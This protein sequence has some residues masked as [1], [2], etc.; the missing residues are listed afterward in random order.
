[1]HLGQNHLCRPA[2]TPHCHHIIFISSFHVFFFFYV[3]IDRCG[4]IVAIL[5]VTV[6][7][8][9]TKYW[10]GCWR[11]AVPQ[12]S[13]TLIV[14]LM[15]MNC[16]LPFTALFVWV[17]KWLLFIEFRYIFRRFFLFSI[18]MCLPS[19]AWALLYAIVVFAFIAFLPVLPYCVSNGFLCRFFRCA[20]STL[21]HCLSMH[22]S[23]QCA[24]FT[25]VC[26]YVYLL[27]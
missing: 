22:I 12:S 1:M 3:C 19:F 20:S 16:F 10:S 4:S 6:A 17:K 27:Y 14:T 25:Y 24:W 21:M 5:H 18:F 23:V 11:Y 26:L 2:T 9:V 7:L 13:P 15:M 8:W